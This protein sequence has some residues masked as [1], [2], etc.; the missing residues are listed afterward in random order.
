MIVN[1]II[2]EY[3]P[4]HNG[5]AYQISR[6]AE[7]TGADYT[8]VVMSGDF[9][10]RGA[11]ALLGKH[12]RA[13]MALMGGAD[14]V[15][16]LP[17]FYALSCAEKF[18]F[19]AVS[20]LNDLGIVDHLC[21]GSEC[22]DISLLKNYSKALQTEDDS[23]KAALKEDL[24]NGLSF[25]KA[26]IN[27]LMKSHPELK[28]DFDFLSFPN[29]I[30]A[31][32]YLQ[33]IKK[34]NSSITPFS[35]LRIGEG[36]HSI[37][38][39]SEYASASAIRSLLQDP[40]TLFSEN[41][42]GKL[43]KLVPAGSFDILKQA[44]LHNSFLSTNDFSSQLI[45]KILLKQEDGFEMYREINTDLDHRILNQFHKFETFDS[46][47]EILK[48]KNLT[49]SR[50]SRALCNILLD[51]P[52]K[53]QDL[54]PGYARVL[55]FKESAKPLLTQI[56]K[57]TK[58]PLVTKYADAKGFLDPDSLSMLNTDL[59]SSQIYEAVLS[60]KEHRSMINE[61]RLPLIKL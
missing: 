28:G 8:I 51:L 48:T 43:Y 14:L 58:I 7:E 19:G 16:E 6:S 17:V 37:S 15:L 33:A 42:L 22:G 18:A 41:L 26:R 27:A 57:H 20:I 35:L 46:F 12:L 11:P 10:Q 45:Y 9:V 24:Q 55:G 5:H 2:A 56:K 53:A 59:R 44:F 47:C 38:C 52:K 29:N 3:N 60:A 4:F 1:G 32:E 50:I 36:Y 13:K 30:L 40:N 39:Q 61:T 25:P 34:L 23:F 54:K 49:Y 21:F 31:L